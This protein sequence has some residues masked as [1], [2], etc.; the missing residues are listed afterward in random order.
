MGLTNHLVDGTRTELFSQGWLGRS[1]EEVHG[2]VERSSD[3]V[4]YGVVRR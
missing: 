2:G 4:M 3:A 1:A